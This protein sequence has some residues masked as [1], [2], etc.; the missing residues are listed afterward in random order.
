[1]KPFSSGGVD[2]SDNAVALLCGALCLHISAYYVEGTT[3]RMRLQFSLELQL[4]SDA[5]E[6]AVQQAQGDA[7]DRDSQMKI[8][9]NCS[10]SEA[11]LKHFLADP[12]SGED[13]SIAGNVKANI[14]VTV[15]KK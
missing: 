5:Y 8:K 1:M 4:G 6:K 15:S 13:A 7:E 11:E 10:N 14:A 3:P 9:F 2:E 12:A